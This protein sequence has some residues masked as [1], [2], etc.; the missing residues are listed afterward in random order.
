MSKPNVLSN[1]SPEIDICSECGEHCE[2]I[3]VPSLYDEVTWES[4][5]CGAGPVNTDPELEDR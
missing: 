1:S 5:C 3:E 2:F 4:N